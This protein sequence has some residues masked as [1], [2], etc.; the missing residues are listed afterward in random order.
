MKSSKLIPILLSVL[1]SGAATSCSPLGWILPQKPI[2]VGPGQI[3]EVASRTNVDVIITN[4]E[5]GKKERRVVRSEG[6]GSW[7]I[8]RRNIL[9]ESEIK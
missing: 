6:D 2:Y 8:G 9:K 7:Y 5:T 1:L 4:K 3:A